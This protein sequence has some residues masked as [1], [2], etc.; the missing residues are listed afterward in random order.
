LVN[1]SRITVIILVAT[2]LSYI[3]T[4]FSLKLVSFHP[5]LIPDV[6]LTYTVYAWISISLFA[7]FVFLL[8]RRL[9]NSRTSK[10]IDLFGLIVIMMV[11]SIFYIVPAI[12]L[13]WQSSEEQTYFAN[14]L[15]LGVFF[16][17]QGWPLAYI[18]IN[19]LQKM[20]NL[21]PLE[22]NIFA[23]AFLNFLVSVILY[24][25][26]KK[27]FSQERQYA[28]ILPLIFAFPQ[29]YYFRYFSDYLFSFIF[30]LLLLYL[31]QDDKTKFFG[32]NVGFFLLFTA[33]VVSDPIT[34]VLLI[35]FFG[36]YAAYHFIWKRE[37]KWFS[38]FI[39]AT[40]IFA[41]WYVFSIFAFGAVSAFTL[42]SALLKNSVLSLTNNFR[43]PIAQTYLYRFLYYFRY[44]LFGL[45]GT[46]SIIGFLI[47]YKRKLAN[48]LALPLCLAISI[49]MIW[50]PVI[51]LHNQD[52]NNRFLVFSFIPISIVTTYALSLRKLRTIAYVIILLIPLSFSLSFFPSTYLTF[53]HTSEFA[54]GNFVAEHTVTGVTVVSDDYTSNF[55]SMYNQSISTFDTISS[56]TSDG[57]FPSSVYVPSSNQIQH[58]LV[59]RSLRQ[60]VVAYVAFGINDSSWNSFDNRLDSGF[61]I[62]YSSGTVQAF[63]GYQ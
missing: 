51:A 41:T 14:A 63:Y 8:F 27:L 44:S 62:I 34:A 1:E 30:L 54:G 16:R 29:V 12:S 19:I 57:H 32:K 36:V 50:L 2:L 5:F 31:V 33:V 39:V 42:N 26:G 23:G 47:L 37:T 35:P 4:I 49:G 52:F 6:F 3:S 25:M 7:F 15:D 11:W 22:T 10:T 45:T 24:M 46:L 48:T 55:I 20:L 18:F 38:T 58:F 61:D 17:N 40:I 28:I 13:Q 60:N 59:V 21:S 56:V 9:S 43:P 53:A